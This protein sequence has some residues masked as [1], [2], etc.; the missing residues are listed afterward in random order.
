MTTIATVIDAAL[1][2]SMSMHRGSNAVDLPATLRDGDRLLSAVGIEHALVGGV[3]MFAYDPSP[4]NTS[5]TDFATNAS[6]AALVDLC[7]REEELST[8][9]FSASGGLERWT[10]RQGRVRE[11]QKRAIIT[12][13]FV[14]LFHVPDRT[15]LHVIQLQTPLLSHRANV[16]G[17]SLD[18]ATVDTMIRT[19][20]L[21]AI[22]PRRE[23]DKKLRDRAAL[24]VLFRL[25]PDLH[26][27]P[28]SDLPAAALHLVREAWE[29]RCTEPDGA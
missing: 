2:V 8:F 16:Q 10:D 3:A 6:L 25:N 11:R 13:D 20:A 14:R 4:P 28:F 26:F 27:D 29:A 1:D 21:S 23:P 17:V 24:I 12:E 9:G 18:V 22:S 15:E 7:E 19:K 5:D